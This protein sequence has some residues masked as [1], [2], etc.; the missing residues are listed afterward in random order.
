MLQKL[1]CFDFF[2]LLL[3]Y[4]Y[5]DAN[6]FRSRKVKISISSNNKLSKLRHCREFRTSIV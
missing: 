5:V 4:D 1:L 6:K 3:E 2:L